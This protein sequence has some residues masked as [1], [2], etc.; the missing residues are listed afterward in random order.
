MVCNPAW[1]QQDHKELQKYFATASP[2]I[3]SA[4]WENTTRDKVYNN[5]II[6]LH[7]QDYELDPLMGSKESG[8]IVTR[9][10]D[11]LLPLWG[12]NLS[13]GEYFLSILVYETAGNKIA[14]NIQIN[15]IKLF[16]YDFVSV[17]VTTKMTLLNGQKKKIGRYDSSEI[18]NGLNNNASKDIDSLFAKLESIQG[19]AISK[20]TTTLKWGN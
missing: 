11:F 4:Q 1:S 6:A 14:I 10:K 19:K 5:F 12:E 16:D 7:L 18:F 20:G 17:S 13:N 8:L 9:P 2:I 3:N 15:G